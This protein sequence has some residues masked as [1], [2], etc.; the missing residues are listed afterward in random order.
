MKRIEITP[1]TKVAD[2]L[3]AFPGLE[4]ELISMAPAPLIDKIRG[5][6]YQTRIIEQP[7]LYKIYIFKIPAPPAPHP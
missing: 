7:P 2:M 3:D 5:K 6:G 1:R 4:Q